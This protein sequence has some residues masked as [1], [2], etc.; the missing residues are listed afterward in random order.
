MKT[1]ND[2]IWNIHFVSRG[3]RRTKKLDDPV[4][5]S[6]GRCV[7]SLRPLPDYPDYCDSRTRWSEL[8]LPSRPL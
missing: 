3:E 1:G 7:K 2:V 8:D 5:I 4:S 6:R